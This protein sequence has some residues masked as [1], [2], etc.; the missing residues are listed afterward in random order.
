M[1]TAEEVKN[2]ANYVIINKNGF[3]GLIDHMG[4]DSAIVQGARVSYG[5]GTK[6]VSEDRGLIRTLL[7]NG[8]TSPFELCEVKF[9]IKTSLFVMRQ[10]VRHRMANLNEYSGRYSVMQDE[11]YVPPKDYLQPQSTTNKQ[12]R[13]GELKDEHKEWITSALEK[14]NKSSYE[15]YESLLNSNEE[16]GYPGLSRELAR[17]VLPVSIMTELYWKCDLNNIFK[18]LRLRDDSHAQQEIQDLAKAMYSLIKPLFPIACEAYEDYIKNAKNSSRMEVS[19]IK[20]LIKNCPNRK[21][22]LLSMKDGLSKRELD[23]FSTFWEI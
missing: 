4:N 22:I 12:G 5:A 16:I 14:H 23:E 8:H 1:A 20:E 17:T 3:I 7:R 15:L 13:A 10:L 11:F 21:D 6:K 9:H 2:N 19:I 18:T